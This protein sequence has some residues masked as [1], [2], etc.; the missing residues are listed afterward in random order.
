MKNKRWKQ[1]ITIYSFVLFM[2]GIM[3][4]IILYPK[5]TVSESERR[6]LAARPVLTIE[7]LLDKS[8]MED[9]EAYLLD[10]FPFREKLRRIKAYFAYDVLMQKENNGIYVANGHASKLEY[11]LNEAS[12]KR[13]AQKMT[14]LKQQYFA[15]QNTWYAMIPD[16]NY[17][18][19]AVNGY[20][21]IDYDLMVSSLYEELG[22]QDGE[23]QYIDIFSSLEIDDY[24]HTDT[25]WKQENL[26]DTAVCIADAL[27]VKEYLNLQEANFEIN[28]I[29][30]FYGVYYG[31]AAL[32]MDPDTISYLTNETIHAAPVWNLEKNMLNGTVILPEEEGALLEPIYQLDVPEGTLR[33]D[34]YDVYVGG[35]ASLQRIKSPNA[36]S[37]KKLIIFRDS[38][39]SSLVPLFLEA[40]SEIVLV[41]LRYISSS[42]L[43][44]YVDFADADILFLYGVSIV[45]NASILK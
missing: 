16:K 11:P 25:H 12:I 35:A 29:N 20:P 28:K 24:Y 19:A 22:K 13:L 32:P 41:D 6:K 18:L 7:S 2:L 36:A 10:H 14:A 23:F 27:G 26:F 5:K 33:L 9:T 21:S 37:D 30:D 43:G 15:E 8:F 44:E 31:Q 40:Y 42:L 45:N 39:T 4:M 17:Y 1:E 34:K 3:I 38:Y